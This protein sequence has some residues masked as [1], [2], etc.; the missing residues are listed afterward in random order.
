MTTSSMQNAIPLT[1]GL[2]A[3]SSGLGQP[4]VEAG[5]PKLL[6]PLRDALPW[7]HCSRRAEPASGRCLKRFIFHDGI[8]RP[9]KMAE[10]EINPFLT[11]PAV[12]EKV[13]AS[14]QYATRRGVLKI[15]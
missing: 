11:H 2:T 9:K 14:T 3:S 13:S 8:G 5:K 4:P 15:L 1:S 6:D 12:Q 10:P 7:R